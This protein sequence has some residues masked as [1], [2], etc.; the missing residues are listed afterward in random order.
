MSM[1][2]VFSVLAFQALVGAFDNFWHHELEARLPQRPSARLELRLHAARE[3]IYGL[4]FAGLAWVH[5]QGWWV[6]LPASLLLVE[7]FITIAD[8]LEE[9]RSRRLPPLERALH[10]VLAVSYGLLLGL[11]GPLWWEASRLASVL[12]FTTHGV[13]SWIFSVASVCVLIWSA[14]NALAVRHLHQLASASDPSTQAAQGAGGP[15]VLVTGGTGFIGS[16]LVARLLAEGR[17]VIVLT[18]D[19][20]QAR[21][22]LGSRVWAVDRLN[23]IPSETRIDAVVNLAGAA[24]LSMPWTAA[25]RQVLLQSRHRTADEVCRLM[26]RLHQRPDVLVCASAVGY[27]GVPADMGRVDEASPAEPGRFQSDLCAMVEHDALA[28]QG[29]GVR[30]VR[31]RPGIVLGHGGG[32][33]PALAV[34]ARLGL[35]A[36]L[37]TGR[38]PVPW[39]HLDDAVGL[40]CH[41][42]TEPTLEGP[43]NAVAPDLPC[44]ARFARTMAASFGRGAWLGIPA[45]VPRMAMGEMSELLLCGQHAVPT[46]ALASG[47]VFRHATLTDALGRLA[48]R[49]SGHRV[50]GAGAGCHAPYGAGTASLHENAN[51]PRGIDGTASFS[52]TTPQM[53]CTSCGCSTCSQSPHESMRP[54][55]ITSTWSA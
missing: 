22:S 51:H 53:R 34:A 54:S 32:A 19:P 48:G 52:H 26:E 46:R 35:A 47:Y 23:D 45:W 7:L 10:T 12:S 55:F 1:T 18:R 20:M 50:G 6:L 28:A 8:F 39:V 14:R 38:Q 9:D 24:I 43:L 15:T 13:W 40:V 44:Q 21:A 49:A 33:Y 27:Y 41:A 3:A 11:I 42:L 4:L 31:L 2:I 29:L 16:A 37:G 5:W 36:V 17:R 30:V 25:R